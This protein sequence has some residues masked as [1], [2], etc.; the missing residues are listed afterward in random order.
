MKAI[1]NSVKQ[2]QLTSDNFWLDPSMIL[3]LTL[4]KSI[5]FL[6]HNQSNLRLVQLNLS[7]IMWLFCIKCRKWKFRCRLQPKKKERRWTLAYCSHKPFIYNQPWDSHNSEGKTMGLARSTKALRTLMSV[8][9]I[10][11]HLKYSLLYFFTNILIL[12]YQ[13]LWILHQ[14]PEEM[15][16]YMYG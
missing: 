4:K 2:S 3:W 10:L 14:F 7:H 9:K 11:G 16:M 13:C 12:L 8:A 6:K 15:W 5:R 1:Y